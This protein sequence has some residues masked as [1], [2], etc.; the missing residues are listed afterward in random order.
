MTGVYQ[1]CGKKHLFRYLGEFD[2]RYS[3]RKVTDWERTSIA[4]KGI[5]GKRLTYR[6]CA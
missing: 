3:H 1:H 6:R 2:F 4:L 5:E